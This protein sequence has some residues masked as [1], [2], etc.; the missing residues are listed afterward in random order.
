MAVACSSEEHHT[1]D[2]FGVYNG[3]GVGERSP[4]VATSALASPSLFTSQCAAALAPLL[5]SCGVGSI[6]VRASPRCFGVDSAAVQYCLHRRPNVHHGVSA[7]RENVSGSTTRRSVAE[8]IEGSDRCRALR[9]AVVSSRCNADGSTASGGDNLLL[10]E[11]PKKGG[12][13]DGFKM[14]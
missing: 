7:W 1:S 11:E 3:G 5:S 9:R 6:S 8:G 4:R 12:E 2:V 14:A 13:E 10:V